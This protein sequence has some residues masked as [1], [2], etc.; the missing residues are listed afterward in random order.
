MESLTPAA[1]MPGSPE[2][3]TANQTKYVDTL[4]SEKNMHKQ[5]KSSLAI[6]TKMAHNV[7]VGEFIAYVTH[8]VVP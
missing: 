3:H 8:V 6:F 7:V 4:S 1:Q 2:S 5:K